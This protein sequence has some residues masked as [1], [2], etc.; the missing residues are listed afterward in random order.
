MS[1]RHLFLFLIF[2]LFIPLLKRYR[3]ITWSGVAKQQKFI[4]TEKLA[5]ELE[6]RTARL[7]IPQMLSFM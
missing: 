4:A 6:K 7:C 5:P 2:L 3:C 1:H